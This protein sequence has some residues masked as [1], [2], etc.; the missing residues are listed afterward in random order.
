MPKGETIRPRYGLEK[1]GI[2][3]STQL[4]AMSTHSFAISTHVFA[5]A[6]RGPYFQN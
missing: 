3:I 2:A 5:T 6:T 4:F 1:R